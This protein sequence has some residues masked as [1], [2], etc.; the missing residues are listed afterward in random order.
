MV[1]GK[2]LGQHRESFAGPAGISTVTL[3][4]TWLAEP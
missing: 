1:V 2:F 3:L 4:I